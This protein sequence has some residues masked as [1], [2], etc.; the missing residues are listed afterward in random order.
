MEVVDCVVVK[1]SLHSRP[2]HLYLYRH[3]WYNSVGTC[4]RYTITLSEAVSNYSWMLLVHL[5]SIAMQ[6]MLA[7]WPNPPLRGSSFSG[8]NKATKQ[9]P[10]CNF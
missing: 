7:R 6:A 2:A 8:L 10:H 3:C 1:F 5:V 4:S 9:I